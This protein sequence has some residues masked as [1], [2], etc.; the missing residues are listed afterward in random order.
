M[1]GAAAAG[2]VRRVARKAGHHLAEHGAWSLATTVL[3][4]LRQR[5]A[6]TSRPDPQG[7]AFDTQHHVETEGKSSL[8][9][10]SIDSENFIYGVEYQASAPKECRE[11]LQRLPIDPATFTF[12]DLGCGK[13]RALLIAGEFGFGRLVGVEF[14]QELCEL[15]R[16]NLNSV[17]QSSASWPEWRVVC[18]DAARFEL[19]ADPLVIYLYNPFEATLM[20]RVAA[21]TAATLPSRQSPLYVVYMNPKHLQPWLVGGHFEPLYQDDYCAILKGATAATRG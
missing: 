1:I 16:R 19:P 7:L 17:Q 18:E 21:A 6:P 14:A 5:V 20:A 2:R 10:L 15:A 12:V 13:G 4:H 3:T 8:N 9:A 11:A